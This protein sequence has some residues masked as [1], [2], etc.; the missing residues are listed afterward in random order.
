MTGQKLLRL[1]RLQF[2]SQV[3]LLFEWYES[4]TPPPTEYA[5][6]HLWDV[7]RSFKRG[8]GSRSALRSNPGTDHLGDKIVLSFP[9][10][11]LVL[12]LY[13]VPILHVG[14]IFY[15]VP[16]LYVVPLSKYNSRHVDGRTSNLL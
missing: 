7:N 4:S 13:V 5:T 15:V 6:K 3:G 2:W 8:D 9:M 1:L 10:F 12:I 16:I 14:S 11:L